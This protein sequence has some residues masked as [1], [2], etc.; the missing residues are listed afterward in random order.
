[1]STFVVAVAVVIVRGERVLAM[2]RSPHKDAG[3][4]I[5]ETLSGRLEIDEQPL[6]AIAREIEEECGL[7]VEI[8][9][10]PIDAYTARRDKTPMF[11]I[12]FRANYVAGE[13]R[14]SDEHDAHEWLTPDEFR[15]R[16]PFVL[17]A[18]AVDRAFG[19]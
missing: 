18:D 4:G 7:T 10:R 13:V 16:T 5:W 14:R 8:D 12:F 17:L 3:A 2:R 1:V 11:V 6:D 19:R 15:A 9:R